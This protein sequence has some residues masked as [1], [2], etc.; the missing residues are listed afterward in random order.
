LK[1]NVKLGGV[2]CVPGP[3]VPTALSDPRNPTIIMGADVMHPAPGSDTPSF[4]ALVGSVDSCAVKYIP[5]TS[6]QLP[7]QEIIS[8]LHTMAKE[9]LTSHLQFKIR[10]EKKSVEAAKPKRLLF[11]RDGVSEG[12]FGQVMEQEVEVL[13]KV[14]VELG[15][16]PKI[17]FLIVGKRHHYRFFPKNPDARQEAD[18]SGNCPAGTVVDKG[19]THPLLF[20]FYIQSHGGLLGT[21]RSAH[22]SVLYDDN[23]FIPDELQGLCYLLCYIYARATRSV[24]IPAPVYYADIV[25][26]R[27]KNHYT[28]DTDLSDAGS[29]VGDSTV[30]RYMD[31]FQPLHAT[32]LTKMYFM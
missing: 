19:I 25:C 13:K 32:H 26:S 18:K 3:K 4:S 14:C 10:M 24:S 21:S 27:A 11:F 9:I 7:R 30:Q 29:N 23:N 16:A 12:Q 28:P 5:R 6:V 1:L 8:D 20:D 2:N 15:I 17:T 31:A 22:Y